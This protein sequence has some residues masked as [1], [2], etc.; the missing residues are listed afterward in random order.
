[1]CVCVSVCDTAWIC[2]CVYVSSKCVCVCVLLPHV[3]T[4]S[5]V[6]IFLFAHLSLP[7]C[8]HRGAGPAAATINSTVNNMLFSLSAFQISVDEGFICAR[9]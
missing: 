5:R 3:H 8:E 2:K 4:P 6:W 9:G 1:M 7:L